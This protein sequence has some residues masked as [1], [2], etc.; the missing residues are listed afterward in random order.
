MKETYRPKN[1]DKI[2]A[3]L[4]SPRDEVFSDPGQNYDSGFE[5]GI[6]AGADAIIEA[7]Q[8]EIKSF[9]EEI[10]KAVRETRYKTI[11]LRYCPVIK[12]EM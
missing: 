7:I 9:A 1:W 8:P 4:E 3:N 6:E 2:V 5:H 11:I 10:E 12:G